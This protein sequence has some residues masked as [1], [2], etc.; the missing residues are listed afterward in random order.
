MPWIRIGIQPKMLDPDPDEMNADP[1]QNLPTIS[2]TDLNAVLCSAL[3][4]A[5]GE[6]VILLRRLLTL[7]HRRLLEGLA[8]PGAGGV[9]QT[10]R[11]GPSPFQLAPLEALAAPLQVRGR[12]NKNIRI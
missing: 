5:A 11:G 12:L 8:T 4:I 1:Q 6:A 9:G 3:V 7:H 2:Y 10:A